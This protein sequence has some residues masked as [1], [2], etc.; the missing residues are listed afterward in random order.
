MRP[1]DVIA[2][3]F[4]IE[5]LAG[6]GGVGAVYR[7]LDRQT[8]EIVA[9][10]TLHQPEQ[11]GNRFFREAR[12]L[13]DLQHPGIV[14]YVAHGT[15]G[16]GSAYLAIEWLEGHDL[17]QRLERGPLGVEQTLVLAAHVAD[18][19]GAAHAGGVIHRDVKPGNLFL[20]GGDLAKVKVL[21][22]GL[23]RL[24][25]ASA[26][27]TGTVLGTP[28]YMAP[29]QARGEREIDPRA[30]VFALGAVLFECL[31]G[32]PPFVA[33]NLMAVLA[34]VLLEE[35]PRVRDLAPDVP[36]DLDAMLARML[37]KDR[38]GRPK[39]G[40]EVARAFAA[41]GALP[42]RS[43]EEIDVRPA[44]LT[45][46]EQRL[47][48]VVLAGAGPELAARPEQEAARIAARFGVDG[49]AVE[50]LMDGSLLAT[51]AARGNATD[52]AAR[53]ARCALSLRSLLPEAPIALALGRAALA[54]Q[55]PVG[56]VIDR[57]ARLVAAA[58]AAP[59][60]AGPRPI[61]VDEVTAGLLDA[62]FEL[63][64]DGAAL[65]LLGEREELPAGRTL[66]G[67]EVPCVGREREL[68]MLR[69]MFEECAAEPVARAVL[70][71]GPAG[72]GKS[73]LRAELLRAIERSGE[74]VEVLIGWGDPAS[75]GS[76]FGIIAPA[77]R[78]AAGLRAGDPAAVRCQ[79]LRARVGRNL[80]GDDLRRVSEFLGE[81]VGVPFPDEDSV[82]LRAARRDPMLMGDRMRR[83]WEDFLDAECAA[84]PVILVLE[85][86][87]WG[88]LPTV[89]YVDAALRGLRARPLF[90]LA[91]GRPEVREAFPRL[92][93]ERGL[94]V[95]RLSELGRKASERLVRQALG[96]AAGAAGEA[97]EATVARIVTQAAGNAFYLEEL[98]R[99]VAEGRGERLPESLLAMVE[100]RL[101]SLEPGARRV[102]RAAS[103][104]GQV[105]WRDG[106][107][108]LLGGRE[109]ERRRLEAD[110]AKLTHAEIIAPRGEDRFPGQP[111][112]AF[113]SLALREAAYATLTGADRRL[114]HRLAGEWLEEAG[115]EDALMLAEHFE[116]GGEARQAIAWYRNAAEQA[117]GAS[118]L[119]AAIDRAERAIRCGADGQTLGALRLLQ[120]EALGWR[121]DLALAEQR[122]LEAMRCLPRGSALW[123]VA[124][125]EL[126]TASG[127]LG[128]VDR[129]AALGDALL[130]PGAPEPFGAQSIAYSRLVVQLVYAGRFD[131]AGA[132]LARIDRAEAQQ[133]PRDPAVVARIHQARSVWAL[134]ADDPSA[135]LRWTEHAVTCFERAGD[136]RSA[137]MQRVNLGNARMQ[138]GAY[139]GAEASLRD[140]LHAA[141]RMSLPFLR[142]VARHNLGFAQAG[143]GALDEALATERLAAEEALAQGDRRLQAAT[144]LYLAHIQLA[145]G[146][147]A[148]AEEAARHALDRA[149]QHRPV[150]ACAQAVLARAL[151]AAGRAGE[152]MAAA[153]EA[154]RLFREIG[155]I[156]GGEALLRLAYAECLHTVGA[157][158]RAREVIREARARL[159][160]RATRIPEPA[161]RQSFLERVG[162]NARTLALARAWAGEDDRPWASPTLLP[163]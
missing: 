5:R 61:R 41:L 144:Q 95:V 94:H 10:K 64:G 136:S 120:A 16:A 6:A 83:A 118:D 66:L 48:Y 22:F 113:R 57:A 125:G 53:A 4:V 128:H 88:D 77:I 101:E 154:M 115:E 111:E 58:A 17:E 13:A 97:G 134:Y 68:D 150:V 75:A 87:H 43:R 104:F 143:R 135:H 141:E 126:A 159:L 112:H 28:A 9:V 63:R 121:G 21:D 138:L 31:T 82:E 124:A 96:D 149:G 23:A 133:A 12:A 30:D 32:R 35:A 40:A 45:A 91:L 76:P 142:T 69:G 8:G 70:V 117:L 105:F 20:V 86:L 139:E 19:L 79:K 163:E 52:H 108:A 39:D 116:R 156:E 132:L 147:P 37:S 27:R 29:E 36:P 162:E 127:K 3:R 62:R 100:A 157:V 60:A 146:A 50:W 38:A 148:E 18:A 26:T 119:A 15:T 59:A 78:R 90:V 160:T 73:R 161:L 65:V 85:N 72:I 74:P 51:V 137:C 49:A 84:Q 1:G 81:L 99:A 33:E 11:T 67:R 54:G 56:E 103:V 114:G 25:T 158:D 42:A 46:G 102:L 131:L 55:Q 93:E 153:T 71:T 145:A 107:A 7:A 89:T 2:E 140:A 122:G 152:A 110:L 151:L 130:A 123:C 92:W 155:R 44:T 14:R 34:K 109:D 24:G 129:L 47:V 80:Q 106:V 98:I